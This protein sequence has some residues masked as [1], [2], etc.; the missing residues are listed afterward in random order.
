MPA[1]KHMCESVQMTAWGRVYYTNFIALFP[2]AFIL[3]AVNEQVK[4]A[5]VVWGANVL[6]PLVMSCVVSGHVHT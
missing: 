2:L 3:P 5:Q 1:V 6:V 4:I